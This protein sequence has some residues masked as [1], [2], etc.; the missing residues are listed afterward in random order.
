M[1]IGCKPKIHGQLSLK[2]HSAI[3]LTCTIVTL[4]APQSRTTMVVSYQVSFISYIA[5]QDMIYKPQL[6]PLSMNN[7]VTNILLT[8]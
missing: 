2:R 4:H 1:E 8:R 6:I 7:F 3:S 5:G